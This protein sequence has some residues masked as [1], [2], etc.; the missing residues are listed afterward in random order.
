[1]ASVKL[2]SQ[3]GEVNG[4]VPPESRVRS[5]TS[6][7][8]TITT[9]SAGLC[10]AT[11]LAHWGC[12]L[13]QL[14]VRLRFSP[15]RLA[16]L[17]R[18]TPQPSMV[19]ST[20]VMYVPMSAGLLISSVMPWESP[21]KATFGNAGS[22]GG[23][24]GRSGFGGPGVAGVAG[25]VS[26]PRFSSGPRSTGPPATGTWALAD[27]RRPT[28][29][30]PAIMMMVR[31][32]VRTMGARDGFRWPVAGVA[33][34]AVRAR[35]RKPCLRMGSSINQYESWVSRSARPT[36]SPTLAHPVSGTSSPGRVRTQ[37]GQCHRYRPY[38]RSPSHFSGCVASISPSAV[39]GWPATPTT[40]APSPAMPRNPAP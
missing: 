9:A 38:D 2:A 34:V 25:V 5:K 16:T 10:L 8:P 22:G 13:R 32:A 18:S 19:A 14:V 30:P 37:T 31:R 6:Q 35:P 21:K 39:P 29:V 1:M 4:R 12:Q 3:A 26:G 23:W 11:L 17:P 7:A 33:G 27:S 20:T 40:T 15:L 24:I 28:A 36:R